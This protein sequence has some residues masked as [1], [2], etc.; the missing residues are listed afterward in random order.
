MWSIES[1]DLYN[2]TGLVIGTLASSAT[3]RPPMTHL[4]T[5]LSIGGAW[6]PLD[7]VNRESHSTSCGAVLRK[8]LRGRFD[9]SGVLP[10]MG[11]DEELTGPWTASQIRG[12]SSWHATGS[13]K[14]RQ[15]KSRAYSAQILRS[16]MGLV[17]ISMVQFHRN[18]PELDALLFLRVQLGT[19][20]WPASFIARRK[21]SASSMLNAW[22]IVRR[23]ESPMEG[24][25]CE[26]GRNHCSKKRLLWPQMHPAPGAGVRPVA[27]M[28]V[29]VAPRCR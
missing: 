27:Y 15:R 22:V 28:C 29:A 12:M 16:R 2:H 20:W 13:S 17:S 23:R 24:S 3:Y 25:G 6:A 21:P 1:G 8:G 7:E 11:E 18:D 19:C 5:A 9:A 26:S 14:P 10:N 4:A